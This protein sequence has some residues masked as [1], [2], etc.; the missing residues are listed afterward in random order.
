MIVY[1]HVL[2]AQSFLN[3]VCSWFQQL[4]I[5]LQDIIRFVS[6]SPLCWGGVCRKQSFILTLVNIFCALSSSFLA[7]YLVIFQISSLASLYFL[8]YPWSFGWYF[9]LLQ[10]TYE[11]QDLLQ[12]HP[13]LIYFFYLFF[14]LVLDFFY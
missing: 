4:K 12:F 13:H 6:I 5:L 2:T 11:N 9:F 7:S 10:I 1:W 8:F 14:Y 3:G